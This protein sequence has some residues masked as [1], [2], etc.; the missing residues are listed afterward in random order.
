[1]TTEMRL[2]RTSDAEGI[3]KS[4]K[5]FITLNSEGARRGK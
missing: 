5:P 1:M 3:S 2:E 4:G